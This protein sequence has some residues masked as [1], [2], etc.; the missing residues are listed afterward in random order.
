M[1][2]AALLL[3][4]TLTASAEPPVI[5]DA[6]ILA[7]FEKKVGAFAELDE[8]PTAQKLKKSIEEAPPT[9]AE[10]LEIKSSPAAS[11]VDAVFLIGSVYKCGR[12]EKW[13]PGGIATAW[14]IGTDGLLV[15]NQHVFA[16][17]SGKV[18]AV[19][20][21]HGNTYPITEILAAD[22]A[23]DVALF[24]VKADSLPTLTLSEPAE[25]GS[26]VQVISH[27]HRNFFFHTFGKV[28]RYTS[29]PSRDDSPETLWMNITADFAK[30][31]S[32]G[33]VIGKNGVVGMVASTRSIYYESEDGSPKG[34]L[35]MVIKNCVP[36]SAIKKLLGSPVLQDGTPQPAL[37]QR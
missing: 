24:R 8:F 22:A 30:G 15:S 25:I 19:C 28:A 16:H 18:M 3:A 20:D 12:C 5:H 26:D 17:A 32:G 14:S 4:A 6:A 2:P 7:A 36:A 33:P 9:A 13:H 10:G 1:K 31:S 29:E 35:Q 27:P 34:P 37:N 11:T 21:R 23:S